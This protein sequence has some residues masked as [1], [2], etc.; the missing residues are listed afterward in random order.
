MRR[1][2]VF[3]LGL[4]LLLSACGTPAASTAPSPGVSTAATQ[5]G[6]ATLPP[7]TASPTTQNAAGTVTPAA[8]SSTPQTAT[9]TLPP[10]TAS[11]TAQN[12][13]GTVTPA[14]ASPTPQTATATLPPATATITAGPNQYQNPVIR[15][16]F[17]DP[18]ILQAG[19]TFY[20]YATNG[21]GGHVQ[22]AT[23]TDLIHWGIPTDAMPALA[24]WV[25]VS[26]PDVWAPEV[27]QVGDHFNLYYTARDQASGKQCVGVATSTAPEGKFKDSRSKALVCQTDEGG[28]ID[29]DPF[30]DGDK[31]YLL[32]KNDGN[33]CGYPTNIYIQEMASDG[34][35]MLGK[36]VSLITNDAPWE[37]NVIEAPSMILH[38]KAYYLFY[39]ANDYGGVPYAV[40]YAKCQAPTGPCTKAAENPILK[41]QMDTP[42][43]VIGPGHQ[44]ILSLNGK[45]WIFYHAWN[46]TGAGLRGDVRQMYIDPLVWKDGKPVVEGPTTAPEPAPLP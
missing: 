46:V 17:P 42:P 34:M 18:F 24:A 20:A 16:N 23:S 39:S 19:K 4:V 3:L 27:V 7:G 26:Q 21:Q 36:P 12:A 32:F 5:A 11:P 45:T 25:K 8:A 30:R 44:A 41:S 31:L 38:E 9:A 28:T 33:C 10:V 2:L 15:S 1:P 35:S 40:G 29:P 22:M 13:A 37:G 6:T 43:F 14:V